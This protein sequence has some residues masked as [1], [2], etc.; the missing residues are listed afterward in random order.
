MSATPK[1]L[2]FAQPLYVTRPMLPPLAAYTDLLQD[3]WA[4]GWLANGG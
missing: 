1:P 2:P 4:S 3:V